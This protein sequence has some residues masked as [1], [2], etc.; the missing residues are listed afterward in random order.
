[1]AARKSHGSPPFNVSNGE[2]MESAK[3][4]IKKWWVSSISMG[5][6]GSLHFH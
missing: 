4:N 3:K 2:P 1:V 5:V 6:P